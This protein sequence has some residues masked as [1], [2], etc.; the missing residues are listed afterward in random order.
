MGRSPPP[1][2]LIEHRIPRHQSH[3]RTLFP[4]PDVHPACRNL[5][6]LDTMPQLKW[7]ADGR[8][9]ISRPQVILDEII[10][11]PALDRY[12]GNLHAEHVHLALSIIGVD[13]DCHGH[14]ALSAQQPRKQPTD[15]KSV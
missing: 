4:D 12:A 8:I 1:A 15:R 6:L 5:D 14:W 3:P 11:H 13:A 9:R 2:A 7:L 10:E